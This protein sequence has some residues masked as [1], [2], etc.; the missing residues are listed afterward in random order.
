MRGTRNISWTWLIVVLAVAIVLGLAL[1]SGIGMTGDLEAEQVGAVVPFTWLG[2]ILWLL[3]LASIVVLVGLALIKFGRTVGTTSGSSH[4]VKP[5]PIDHRCPN[6]AQ[7][8]EDDWERCPNCGQPL[9][10]VTSQMAEPAPGTAPGSTPRS[11]REQ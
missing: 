1:F 2:G 3:F 10:R 5:Q 8:V 11:P 6:C 7:P 9:Q 4:P